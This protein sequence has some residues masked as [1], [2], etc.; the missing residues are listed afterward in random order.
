MFIARNRFRINRGFEEAFEG[1]RAG[2]GTRDGRWLELTLAG[3]FWQVPLTQNLEW[4]DQRLMETP[5][6][7]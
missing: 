2:L 4:L 1:Q 5:N 6:D 7:A 3:R